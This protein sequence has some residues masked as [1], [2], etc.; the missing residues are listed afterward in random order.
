MRVHKFGLV[1]ILL[2][3]IF[4]CIVVAC[5]AWRG[6]LYMESR[7]SACWH[8]SS[9]KEHFCDIVVLDMTVPS[10]VR[11]SCL[12]Q[13]LTGHGKRVTIPFWKSGRTIATTGLDPETIAYYESLQ[14]YISK[15]I[16]KDVYVTPLDHPTSCALI[17]YEQEGDFINWHYDVN[18]FKGRF[19]TLIVPLTDR[20]TCTTFV[21]KKPGNVD[22]KLPVMPGKA[23]LFEGEK[24]FHMATPLCNND[25]PR[26]ILSM[27]FSTDPL[28][29]SRFDAMLYTFKNK[30]YV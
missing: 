19:F 23:I 21:Y 30:S 20:S 28:L 16:G 24:V 22:V 2:V 7:H 26:V 17:V 18:Y 5:M 10:F 12:Q 27:Q 8:D 3:A 1:I 13:V 29:K 4:T 14:P 25:V 9:T 11:N 6:G 15:V